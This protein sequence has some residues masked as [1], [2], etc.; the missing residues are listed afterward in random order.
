VVAVRKEETAMSEPTRLTSFSPIFPVRDLQAALAHYASLGF[1][2]TAYAGDAE[3]GFADRDGVGLHLAVE[4]GLD[5]GIGAAEAYLYV[6][7]ADALA[8]EWSR[9]GIG[10]R[11][12]PVGDTPYNLREGAHIDPDNNVIRFGSPMSTD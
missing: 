4:P 8:A 12:R 6:T 11:I 7:D 3:Y 5:P 9:P 2:T 10:G 1:V